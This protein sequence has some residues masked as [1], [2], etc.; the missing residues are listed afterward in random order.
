MNRSPDRSRG[1]W[2]GRNKIVALSIKNEQKKGKTFIKYEK[3]Q[4]SCIGR[5]F[6]AEIILLSLIMIYIY[7][8]FRPAHTGSPDDWSLEGCDPGVQDAD[9]PGGQLGEVELGWPAHQV[10]APTRVRV[11]SRKSAKKIVRYS[12][13]YNNVSDPVELYLRER[14]EI[15]PADLF[16]RERAN[17]EQLIPRT[18]PPPFE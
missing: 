2:P 8:Y 10:L 16:L 9:G 12:P 14:A 13:N 7:L 11:L 4:L 15:D 6:L 17:I 18:P 5:N 1:R 3:I